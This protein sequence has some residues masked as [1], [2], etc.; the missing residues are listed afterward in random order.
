MKPGGTGFR[1]AGG[2]G[3]GRAGGTG[4]AAG[5]ELPAVRTAPSF[6]D[7]V[8]RDG[9][10]DEG[11]GR[12]ERR[13]MFP[14]AAPLTEALM[15]GAGLLRPHRRR[16]HPAAPTGALPRGQLYPIGCPRPGPPRRAPR[17]PLPPPPRA[18]PPQ[19]LTGGAVALRGVPRPAVLPRSREGSGG[20]AV[21][22]AARRLCLPRALALRIWW[23]LKT[24]CFPPP[25]T[26]GE[27]EGENCS[28]GGEGKGKGKK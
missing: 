12:E 23:S 1:G 17:G 3:R 25:D 11:G 21:R 6:I 10:G 16:L 9:G 7:P 27:G 20:P 26:F 19:R 28:G 18:P 15:S 5:R 24:I 14:G 2:A 4:Y 22:A 8:R 13:E